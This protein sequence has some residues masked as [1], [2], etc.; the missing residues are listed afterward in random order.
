METFVKIA[1]FSPLSSLSEQNFRHEN[2]TYF[3]LKRHYESNSRPS[4]ALILFL[5]PI[6]KSRGEVFFILGKRVAWPYFTS[7]LECSWGYRSL[8][9]AI[10]FQQDERMWTITFLRSIFL[11]FFCFLP[12]FCLI[13]KQ[14]RLDIVFI[15]AS[16]P[17]FYHSFQSHIGLILTLFLVYFASYFFFW[18]ISAFF[19]S[20]IFDYIF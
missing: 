1:L 16:F 11:R 19:S 17:P 9:F 20:Y 8:I 7:R 18:P 14:Y 10:N 2:S 12:Y 6:K 13:L 3:H 5:L 4:R 15:L